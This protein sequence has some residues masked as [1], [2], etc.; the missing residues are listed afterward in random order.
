M[1][2]AEAIATIYRRLDAPDWAAPNLDALADV[3]RDLS[4]LPVGPV[5]IV[6]PELAEPDAGELRAVLQVVAAETANG[7]RPVVASE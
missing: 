1:T 2:L 5:H 4:W 6:I 7:S 3:L